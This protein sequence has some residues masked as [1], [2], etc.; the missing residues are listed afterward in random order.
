MSSRGTF[1]GEQPAGGGALPGGAPPEVRIADDAG[2]A[3]TYSRSDHTHQGAV[4]YLDQAAPDRNIVGN[5]S[6]QQSLTGV[7]VIGVTN[8][9]SDTSGAE[10]GATGDYSTVIGG[11]GLS[12]TQNYAT[13]IGGSFSQASG[14]SSSVIGGGGNVASGVQSG[15]FAGDTNTA[16]GPYSVS[17]GGTL[18]Q[19]T[20]SGA[21]SLGG[22]ACSAGADLATVI[23]GE[24]NSVSATRSHVAGGTDNQINA[25]AENSAITGGSFNQIDG[26]N[27]HVGGGVRN[28]VGADS[29]TAV[30]IG[31]SGKIESGVAH[32]GG[33]TEAAGYGNRQV[34]T[35]VLRGDTPGDDPGETVQLGFGGFGAAP[36]TTVIT[37]TNNAMINLRV[38]VQ[39]TVTSGAP[40]GNGKAFAFDGWAYNDEGIVAVNS[41][42]L[43]WSDTTAAAATHSVSLGV[44]GTNG[45][46]LTGEI[47]DLFTTQGT[48]WVAIV[49]LLE[50]R[51]S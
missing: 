38:R 17:L 28:R 24:N 30:G 51:T 5:R 8:L 11:D 4:T 45:L 41:F 10:P 31:A 13:A 35:I 33:Q 23:G 27:S 25:L 39:S 21:G 37:T 32:A 44:D 40:A 16:S 15:V 34:T 22:T 48:R 47:G 50:V 1:T 29:A 43:A 36:T 12:A 19:A 42:T 26:A 20:G 18:C 3:A 2:A 9:G 14:I 6:A 46:T 7:G 49:E